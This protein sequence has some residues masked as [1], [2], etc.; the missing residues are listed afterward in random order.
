MGPLFAA[1][2]R[3]DTAREHEGETANRGALK[4]FNP[5]WRSYGNIPT[6]SIK[7]HL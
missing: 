5:G 7:D 3:R 2:Q 1:E 4:R 6:A